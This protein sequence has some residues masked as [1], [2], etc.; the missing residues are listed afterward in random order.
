[1]TDTV[2]SAAVIAYV[3]VP[4]RLAAESPEDRVVKQVG[5]EAALALLPEVKPI[6]NAMDEADPFPGIGAAFA[7]AALGNLG[8][9]HRQSW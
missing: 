5:A 7:G 2:L 9:E 8:R 4:G 1:M 6:L 3:G